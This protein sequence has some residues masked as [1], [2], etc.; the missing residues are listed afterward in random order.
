[1]T[2]TVIAPQQATRIDC[3]R[4]GVRALSLAILPGGGELAFCGHH[5]RA[6]EEHLAAAGAQMVPLP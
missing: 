4:C 3:D 2:T 6:H 1:M 5:G